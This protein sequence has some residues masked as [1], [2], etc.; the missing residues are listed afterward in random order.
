MQA[1]TIIDNLINKGVIIHSPQS[2]YIDA[3]TDPERI[4]EGVIIHAGCRL[5][6]K[7]TSI[8]P[9]CELGAESPVTINNCQLGRNV[10]LGGGYFSGATLLDGV[11]LGDGAHVRPGT[12]LEEGASAGHCVGLKQTLLMPFATLGSLINFCDCLMAGGTGPKN[13][14]EVGSSYVHFNFTA[15]QD[16]AT[17]SMAGDVPRGVMLDKK[18]IFLGG[19]GGLVGPAIIEYGTIIAAGTICR[20]DI[21]NEDKLVFGQTGHNIKEHSYDTEVYGNVDR[22]LHHNFNYIGNLHALY[23]WYKHVRVLFGPDDPFNAMC[24]DGAIRKIDTMLKERIKRLEQLSRKLE[25]SLEQATLRNSGKL[26]EGPFALQ[27][28]F[29]ESWSSISPQLAINENDSALSPEADVFLHGIETTEKKDYIKTIKTL[30]PE[31]KKSGTTWLQSVV[32]KTVSLYKEL[33]G[34]TST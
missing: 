13:H 1:K 12:L 15:H 4:A 32:D 28:Q 22:I 10:S 21:H 7:E 33:K 16:K 31:I 20:R 6:G 5:S 30:T 29:S 25:L 26:P 8:G 18:P 14:S 17:A 27:K 9:G 11:S 34:A 2:V 19:Q 23:Q 3:S 24:Y